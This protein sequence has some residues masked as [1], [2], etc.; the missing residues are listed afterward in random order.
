MDE[1]RL[2]VPDE[3]R[4]VGGLDG[5]LEG[6]EQLVKGERD[7]LG[8]DL[9]LE[10]VHRDADGGGGADAK[11]AVDVAANARSGIE[12][13]R[14][15]GFERVDRLQGLV[16]SRDVAHDPPMRILRAGL[17]HRDG[18]RDFVTDVERPGVVEER[19]AH[20]KA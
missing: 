18:G 6:L 12:G 13:T 8:R 1:L 7:V 20:R 14:V 2:V 5:G 19:G 3:L 11:L 9:V 15:R 10:L 16:Q 4:R 17:E